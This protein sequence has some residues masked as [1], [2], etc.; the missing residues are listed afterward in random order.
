MED[1]DL[2]S[3][4]RS[5]LPDPDA[6]VEI[7]T[8]TGS[9]PQAIAD[10]ARAQNAGLIITGV[11]RYNSVGDYVLGTAVEKIIGQ[12]AAPVLV[13]KQRPHGPYRRLLC[14]VDFSDHSGQALATALRLFPDREVIVLHAFHVPFE[15][16]QKDAYVR[17][18][19]EA[20]IQREFAVF[21]K[22]CSLTEQERQRL[23]IRL[24]YGGV[25]RVI[26]DEI[27]RSGVD[28]VVFGTHGRGGFRQATIG[29]IASRLLQAVRPDTL[30]VPPD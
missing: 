16:R 1:E 28:L 4:V 8:P 21:L 29:S 23:N 3:T 5:V 26:Q 9:A 11:A 13:V 15:S 17:E 10:A 18:E 2:A 14:A 30:V 25:G 27:D 20:N 19:T 7:L 22:K 24:G 6:D 12:A